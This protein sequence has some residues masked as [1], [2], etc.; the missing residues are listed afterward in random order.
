MQP[1]AFKGVDIAL[2]LNDVDYATFLQLRKPLKPVGYFCHALRVPDPA[3]VAVGASLAKVLR[4]VS[5]DLKRKLICGS[6]VI[7]CFHDAPLCLTFGEEIAHCQP[8]SRNYVLGSAM[9]VT[10]QQ[11]PTVFSN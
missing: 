5:D 2:T 10:I 1:Y 3:A 11:S 7:I 4:F 6:A 9:P 8:Q